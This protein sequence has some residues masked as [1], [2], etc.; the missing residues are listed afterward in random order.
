MAQVYHNDR[1]SSVHNIVAEFPTER[2]ISRVYDSVGD[3]VSNTA[4]NAAPPDAPAA[5]APGWA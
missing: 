3:F 1:P 5:P 2:E 4:Q